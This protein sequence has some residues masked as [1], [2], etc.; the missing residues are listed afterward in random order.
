MAVRRRAPA[1][2]TQNAL[3]LVRA[4]AHE[5]ATFRTIL[6]LQ[7]ESV[8]TLLD[9]QHLTPDVAEKLRRIL[10]TA[11]AASSAAARFIQLAREC[12]WSPGRT[13]R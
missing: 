2:A 10:R 1:K 12:S 6:D 3:D 8:A 11:R 7:S 13:R 9:G 5:L 4:A